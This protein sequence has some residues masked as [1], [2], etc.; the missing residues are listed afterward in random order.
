MKLKELRFKTSQDRA[1]GK[2]SLETEL[3]N[4]SK[5]NII[6]DA[7]YRLGLITSPHS[8]FIINRDK[9]WERGGAETYIYRF[10]IKEESQI[11]KAY[12]IKACVAFSVDNNLDKILEQWIERRRLALSNGIPTPSL[13]TYGDGILIEEFISYP[14]KD[15]LIKVNNTN[16]KYFFLK[17]LANV[18]VDFGQDLGPS[19]LFIL[20]PSNFFFNMIE[21]LKSWDIDLSKADIENLKNIFYKQDLLK[22]PIE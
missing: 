22:N 10:R 7:L 17:K 13:I 16:K 15:L 11:E 20:S 3:C 9:N 14:F 2:W 4:I 1:I 18:L 21:S 19:G 6:N 12:I 8:Q 5:T